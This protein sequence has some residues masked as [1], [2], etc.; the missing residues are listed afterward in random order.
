MIVRLAVGLA[1]TI[2]ALAIV[3][4]RVWW[5][6][7]LDRSAQPAP[8]RG[9]QQIDARIE[10]EASEVLGQRK[11]LKWT[12]PGIAHAFAFWGFLVLG[13]T[14]VEAFGA[15]FEAD[16]YIRPSIIGNNAFIG[17]IEDLFAVLV[18]VA[19]VIF[20]AIRVKNAP[21]RKGRDSRFFGSHLG[22]AWLVL[23]LIFMVISTLLIY[24]GAQINTTILTAE[25]GEAVRAFPYDPDWAFASNAVAQVLEPLGASANEW[26]ETAFILLNIGVILGFLIL[27]LYSK[28]AHI[29]LAPINVFFSR[30]PNGL[31]PLLPVFWN[32]QRV[33]FED[34]KDDDSFGRGSIED[35][36]WKGYLDFETCTECGRCQSQCPAWNTGKPLSPK[37]LI[38]N[39]R[40]HMF[41]AAPY[42]MSGGSAM[43]EEDKANLPE[44][45]LAEIERP[46]V[47]SEPS[48]E[49]NA[50]VGTHAAHEG[51]VI[52]YDVLWSCTTC[53]ACVEQCPVDIEH[54]DHIVDMRRY[55]VLVESN[56]P[57]EAGVMLRNIENKGN[58]WGMNASARE[59]WTQALDFEVP[60]VGEVE[61]ADVDYLLWVGCAGAL[62]DKAKKVSQAVAE[63]LHAAD[64]SF[65]ILGSEETCTGDPARRLGNEFVFYGQAV[66]N[67]EMLNE[68]GAKRVITTCPHC[69][70]TLGNE[71]PQFGGN[72]E[73]IPHT[74]L[75]SR[76]V[77]EGRL[78]PVESVD[79]K[80]T[81]HDPC[82]LG[83]HNKVYTPPREV[84]SNVPGL[85]T[86]EMHR[87]KDRGF[88]CGAGGARMWLEEKIGKRVNVERTDEAL[89]LDPDI[90]STA[91][92][93]CIVMLDDAVTAKKQSGEAREG[94]EVLDV[95]QILQ[96]SMKAKE[97][98]AVA[99]G[100][101]GSASEVDVAAGG[102][103]VIEGSAVPVDPGSAAPESPS[104]PTSAGPVS[105]S[106][107][108]ESSVPA[109]SS[110]AAESSGSGEPDSSDLPEKPGPSDNA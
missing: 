10:A 64:V 76:L 56:F 45:V 28:H 37:L 58:P 75:L 24:R 46:L 110:G 72:Y 26:I 6:F 67:V 105:S 108:A 53:G 106:G 50:A 102:A 55:Q 97:P 5:L 78:T 42:L 18:L 84:L 9:T 89:A 49:E 17:F 40:D 8:I 87:H 34:P 2:A 29:F 20:A 13:L 95:S 98:V 48:E 79:A 74:V 35:F 63:L 101:G 80:V 25:E 36:T 15:L 52:P 57:S 69:M 65:A 54:I 21:K 77:V 12:L 70:N 47:G 100:S 41:A 22:A 82:Y 94:V 4:H 104:G 66:Q 38:M 93:F 11:L 39:L 81:Y 43:S 44:A 31:G 60:R 90:I 33:D 91:C 73:I 51:S 92:P 71:Y 16:F 85:T 7:T 99:V 30:R 1:I 14:I 23:F 83:R 19:L 59:D 32:G 3:G 96:R 88:C 27:V 107:A 86:Q 62:E 61:L 103:P 68:V 109:A